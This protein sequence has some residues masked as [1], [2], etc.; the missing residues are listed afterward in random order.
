MT[1]PSS[2]PAQVQLHLLSFDAPGKVVADWLGA[3]LSDWQKE[4]GLWLLLEQIHRFDFE[5]PD[6]SKIQ[7][8]IT[9]DSVSTYGLRGRLFWDT[10]QIEWRRLNPDRIRVVVIVEGSMPIAAPGGVDAITETHM[11]ELRDHRLIL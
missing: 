1:I 9:A 5:G 7:P 8:L 3:W 11:M 2:P 6:V 4:A 10:G